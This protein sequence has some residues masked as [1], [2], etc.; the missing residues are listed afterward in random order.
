[1]QTV[2]IGTRVLNYLIDTIIIF[3]ISAL[4]FHGWNVYVQFYGYQGYNYGWFFFGG[5]FVYYA[6]FE[7]IFSRTP[8][9]WFSYTKVVNKQ[10]KKPSIIHILLRS[11]T[12][13]LLIDSF[14]IPF[15]DKPL[16]DYFSNTEV[17]QA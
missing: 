9:K 16:H 17:V 14:F 8:G 15:L 7:G 5:T 1:M 4:C 10:G 11:I 3:I 13:L 2:G 6:L 12:R